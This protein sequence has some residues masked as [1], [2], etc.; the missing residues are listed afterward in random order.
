MMSKTCTNFGF[1]LQLI[2]LA[3]IPISTPI[4][5][6]NYKEPLTLYWKL[7]KASTQ[8]LPIVWDANIV[9]M[10]NIKKHHEQDGNMCWI[11][12][13]SLN[14]L[15][16]IFVSKLTMYQHPLSGPQFGEMHT[17]L[18]CMANIPSSRIQN[19][20]LGLWYGQLNGHMCLRMN[21]LMNALE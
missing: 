16:K 13:L 6:M 18:N 5:R 1:V 10:R 8:L 4:E 2:D 19:S 17:T 9:V 7:W 3:R 15:A 12:R 21:A 20:V 11:P 14:F